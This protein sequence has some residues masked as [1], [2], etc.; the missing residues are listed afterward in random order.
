[1]LGSFLYIFCQTNAQAQLKA[2][3]QMQPVTQLVTQVQNKAPLSITLL[4]SSAED[5]IATLQAHETNERQQAIT[6]TNLRNQYFGLYGS[7]KTIQVFQKLANYINQNNIYNDLTDYIL[8][9]L[10]NEYLAISTTPKEK[11]IALITVFEE[12]FYLLAAQNNCRAI[13][14]MLLCAEIE[15]NNF[16]KCK[17]YLEKAY[18]QAQKDNCYEGQIST[19]VSKSTFLYERNKDYVAV[20]NTRLEALALMDSFTKKKNLTFDYM[21]Q[22]DIYEK[23][24][25]IHYKV[26]NYDLALE[27]WTKCLELLHLNKTQKNRFTTT[28]TNNIG[29]CH[30]KM[31][32]YDKAFTYFENTIQLAK[33]TKDTVWVGI[34]SG[35]IGD[36]FLA[37]KQYEKALP[38]LNEDAKTSIKYK[39]HDNTTKTI[40]QIAECHLHLQNPAQA[41]VYLDS[42]ERM[43]KKYNYFIELRFSN[44]VMQMR[45]KLHKN[46]LDYYVQTDNKP[47]IKTYLSSFLGL[48]DSLMKFRKGE[49]L[50]NVQKVYDVEHEKDQQRIKDLEKEQMSLKTL[51]FIVAFGALFLVGMFLI[52]NSRMKLRVIN[53]KNKQLI[54]VAEANRQQI[55]TL[56][57]LEEQSKSI[58]ASIQY[59]KIIQ[60]SILPSH[61]H[62]NKI[63]E[64][65]TF[66][67]V[68]Q[69]KD[70]VSGD[71][72]WIQQKHD[73]II[74]VLADCTGHGVPGAMMSMLANELLHKKVFQK[75]VLEPNIL[76]KDL[77]MMLKKRLNMKETKRY[78]GMDI[79]MLVYDKN[80]KI[81]DFASVGSV[82]ACYVKDNVV[83]EFPRNKVY[84]P[85]L[86]VENAEIP[87]FGK[88]S[89]QLD[90]TT[91]F[92]MFSDGITDQFD[93]EYR[94][95]FGR[96][97]F[98][99]LLQD[100]QEMPVNEQKHYIETVMNDWKKD[101]PQTD[102]ISL[103][104]F[105]INM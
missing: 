60:Q 79:A 63:L 102:D 25:F 97:K 21:Y 100:L 98:L 101:A 84:V 70:I 15:E 91:Q 26:N 30:F 68:Y 67:T 12:K 16:A 19:L 74:M 62:I 87:D 35:N 96:K 78:D 82:C 20:L 8:D 94:K 41:R 22:V 69:P 103:L 31:N 33:D 105:E 38:Y 93:A 4:E 27:K 1:M 2:H 32:D 80:T 77:Y 36:I 58:T 104:A 46:W 51:V 65:K 23:T 17:N 99:E 10:V 47:L 3:L 61:L 7:A 55:D 72:Y 13:K 86:L 81:L 37:K 66:F 39:E 85:M 50:S 42:T 59:A 83:V 43:M 89:I 54:A 40:L 48:Q 5:I 52:R 28:I 45:A 95:K 90:K 71:F 9:N 24:A 75:N 92:Y 44:D 11:F 73:K 34:A 53:I 49:Q 14:Y 57:L 29:L 88:F 56:E 18:Q 76:L 64:N 6:L